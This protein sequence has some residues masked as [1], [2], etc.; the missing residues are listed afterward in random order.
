M[1]EIPKLALVTGASSGIGKALC[2]LLAEK[3]INLMVVARREEPLHQLKQELSEISV[4]I[5]SADLS[6]KNDRQHLIKEIHRHAPELVINNA[7]FGLYG[8]CLTYSTREQ[9]NLLEVNGMA[10]LELSLEAARTLISKGKKGVIFN[11]SSAAGFQIGPNMAVYSASKTFVNYFSQALD[12]EVKNKGIRV[13]AICPGMVETHFT[14]RAGGPPQNASKIG[15]MTP[16]FV[17]HEIWKQIQAEDPIRIIDWK[18]RLLTFFSFILPTS[19]SADII[20]N[21]IAKRINPRQFINIESP[22]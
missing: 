6:N 11:I 8:E 15:V 22:E 21:N 16:E 12:I 2:Y 7:G 18:Y 17:A 14:E 13:M 19:W 20:K 5:I 9:L 1:K 10:V 4:Q 3:G